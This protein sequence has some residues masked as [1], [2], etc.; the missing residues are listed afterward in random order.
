MPDEYDP[1]PVKLALQEKGMDIDIQKPETA[2]L[3]DELYRLKEL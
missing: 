1:S 2:K 3:D